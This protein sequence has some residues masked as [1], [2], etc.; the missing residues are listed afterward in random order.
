MQ[1]QAPLKLAVNVNTA[2]DDTP[3]SLTN[4]SGEFGAYGSARADSRKRAG[5]AEGSLVARSRAHTALEIGS[6]DR[7]P[8]KNPR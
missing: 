8:L 4:A 7:G 5:I 3:R 6:G 2:A 1:H